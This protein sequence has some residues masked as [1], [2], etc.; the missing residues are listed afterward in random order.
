[1]KIT[2]LYILYVS[3]S[4]S[5][6][7]SLN[8]SGDGQYIEVA[9]ASAVITNSAQMTISGWIHPRNTDVGWPDL[10]AFFGIRN[11]AF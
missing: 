1:M 6:H 8:L 7:Y 2:L 5:Q 10:D 3:L 11:E 4:Y 9:N